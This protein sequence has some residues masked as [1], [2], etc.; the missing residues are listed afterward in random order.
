MVEGVLMLAALLRV[1][2]FHPVEGK[3]PVP[4]AHLTV[5]SKAGIWLGITRR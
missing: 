1:W 4:V 2:R 5:R 3:V